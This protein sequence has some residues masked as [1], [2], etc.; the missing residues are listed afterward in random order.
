MIKFTKTQTVF[1]IA[2]I[3]F[4]GAPGEY[5][6]ILIGS[7]FY[8]GHKIVSDAMKGIFDKEAAET[9]IKKQEEFSEKTGNPGF[10]DIV[11]STS[12]ALIRYVEYVSDVTEAP[13][14]VD[15]PTR[16]VRLPVMQHI[17][18]VGLGERAIYNSI[19]Y[20]MD[21]QE[22]DG[23]TSLSVK[24]LIIIAFSP[25]NVRA[26]G[27]IEALLGPEG[28]LEG[29][30]RTGAEN[31]LIDTAVFDPPSIGISVK[32]ISLI[33]EA[34]GLPVG[35]SPAN[36]MTLWR[37]IRKQKYLGDY[38]YD[39]CFAAANAIPVVYG[40]D[41]LLYGPI[42]RSERTFPVVAMADAIVAYSGRNDGIQPKVRNHALYKIF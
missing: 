42:E 2:G 40:A 21:E 10:L 27:R 11:G 31:I 5:P 22:I 3:N 19:D 16:G 13:F 15:G 18:E 26:T 29:A 12:D 7:I 38:A 34:T 23:L 20:N 1:D 9:L 35:C 6:T 4:G 32:V 33:K 41:F 25:K 17:M 14:L 37:K 30:K 36:A 24:N 39:S 28:L 8:D